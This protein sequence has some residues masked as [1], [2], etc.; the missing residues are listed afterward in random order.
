MFQKGLALSDL[1]F[2]HALVRLDKRQVLILFWMASSLL[3]DGI[4]FTWAH[5]LALEI[6]L[7]T[8]L[9]FAIPSSCRKPFVAFGSSILSL[10]CKTSPSLFSLLPFPKLSVIC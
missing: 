9:S 4:Q 5:D 1:E 8:G 7:F 10:S 3:S 2:A 6:K